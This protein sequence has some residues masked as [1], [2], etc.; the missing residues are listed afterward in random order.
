MRRIGLPARRLLCS[1]SAPRP[2]LTRSAKFR[3]HLHELHRGQPER[4]TDVALAEHFRVPIANVQGA[5][6]LK[7]LELDEV[8]RGAPLD[9]ELIALDEDIEEYL[10]E[11]DDPKGPAVASFPSPSVAADAA[12]SDAWV[13]DIGLEHMPPE[14][15]ALLVRAVARRFA[16][17]PMDA[18]L[19][20][21]SPAEIGE[22]ARAVSGSEAISA[23]PADRAEA[24]RGLLAAVAIE[25]PPELLDAAEGELDLSRV[26]PLPPTALPAPPRRSSASDAAAAAGGGAA[27]DGVTQVGVQTGDGG[28]RFSV[29]E[30]LG[31]DAAAYFEPEVLAKLQR[32][33]A[34]DSGEQLARNLALREERL[35]GDKAGIYQSSGRLLFAEVAKKGRKP[36]S[37]GRVWVSERDRTVRDADDAEAAQATRRVLPRQAAPRIKRNA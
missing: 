10:C 20:A 28:Q 37:V 27:D 3:E 9:P 25:M 32:P 19:E 18:A 4:W 31:P 30:D 26:T 12:A 36:T 22:L 6:A 34:P 16:E 17:T 7:Q 2:L 8:S 5:L 21:L 11:D 23:P 33:R 35:H 29:V 13:P 14:Q 1:S 24:L 15:E